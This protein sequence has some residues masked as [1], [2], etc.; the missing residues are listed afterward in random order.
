MA[1]QYQ[2]VVLRIA[3]DGADRTNVERSIRE[4]GLEHRVQL[5]GL[6]RPEDVVREMVWCD[7]FALLAWDELF[8]G[9]CVEAM[10]CGK[11]VVCAN[12]GGINDVIENGVHGFT[13]APHDEEAAALALCELV[14]SASLREQMG[15]AARELFESRL[16]WEKNAETMEVLFREVI[17][18]GSRLVPDV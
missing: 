18:G 7:L 13:V 9:V 17:E 8:S 15:R 5:L 3:G 10:A 16:T 12:D 6:L 2:H 1:Q 4:Q 11:P 14:A